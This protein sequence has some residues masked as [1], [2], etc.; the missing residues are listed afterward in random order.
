MPGGWGACD[1]GEWI[2]KASWYV[3]AFLLVSRACSVGEDSVEMM[4]CCAQIHK[5]LNISN[6]PLYTPPIVTPDFA[7]PITITPTSIPDQCPTSSCSSTFCFAIILTS[8]LPFYND[9]KI[10]LTYS[11]KNL[12]RST[13][14]RHL[15]HPQRTYRKLHRR[16]LN[17][18]N[19]HHRR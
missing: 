12:K 10:R 15:L 19:P 1:V 2:S 4:I 6:S 14:P 16:K 5:Y 8:I 13:Y 3:L 18:N 11:P 9:Y 17:T 7:L